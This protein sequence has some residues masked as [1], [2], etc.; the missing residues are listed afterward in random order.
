MDNLNEL[1]Q[2][3]QTANT[4]SLPALNEML[5]MVKKFRNQKLRNKYLIICIAA[6][7]AAIMAVPMFVYPSMMMTT[8]IGV[9]L[10]I[11]SCGLL[12]FTNTR[13]LK[14]FHDLDDRNNK[15]FIGFL[16]K[17]RQ[18]QL[19]YYKKT[20]VAGLWLSS[21]GL[22][23][24]LYEFV[25]NN[26]LLVIIGYSITLVYILVIWFVLRPRK[27]NKE[28]KKLNETMERLNTLSKQINPTDET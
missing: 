4:D 23:F 13:S 19:Y 9:L 28:A 25:H 26:A 11:S 20:Q 27:F 24:Y 1:K 18:N 6:V 12:I 2:L 22:L 8:R 7:L 14:R 3:W 21:A 10:L 15:E 16:E 17:T 5:R